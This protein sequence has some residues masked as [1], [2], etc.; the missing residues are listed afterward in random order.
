M[1][2]KA[3]VREYDRRKSESKVDGK[4]AEKFGTNQRMEIL[5]YG[6]K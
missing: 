2:E 4:I 3:Y 6:N 5:N 1:P